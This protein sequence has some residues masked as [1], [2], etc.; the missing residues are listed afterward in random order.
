MARS[1]LLAAGLLLALPA[2]APAETDTLSSSYVVERQSE[3][4]QDAVIRGRVEGA[5]GRFYGG[6]R[7]ETVP[8]PD[9]PG[10]V[11][12]FFGVRPRIGDLAMD[13]SYVR[14]VG[15]ACCGAM[16]M[17]LGREAGARGRVGARFYFFAARETAETE[18]RASVTVFRGVR[19]A[20]AA[21]SSFSTHNF[22]QDAGVGFDL[23]LS[24]PLSDLGLSDLRYRDAIAEAA[25]A[26][27]SP[28]VK[29]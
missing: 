13:V 10:S 8:R 5:A 9:D 22:G 18:A 6:A 27:M 12:V 20:G 7:A 19:V 17:N 15:P 28:E 14:D 21:G 4:R 24:R 16:A 29:F 1:P 2:A 26:Q 11:D 25:K 3:T 23:G